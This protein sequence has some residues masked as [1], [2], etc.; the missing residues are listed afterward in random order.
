MV[1]ATSS[2]DS[3][4]K[5][6]IVDIWTFNEYKYKLTDKFF[7]LRNDYE[8]SRKMKG[9]TLADIYNLAKE[10]YNYLPEDLL[11]K[12][13]YEKLKIAIAG[14]IKYPSNREQYEELVEALDNYL[15]KARIP[16]VKGSVK[17]TPQEG[18]APLNVTLRGD[19]RDETGTKIPSYNYVWWVDDAGVRKVI[20]NKPS[21]NYIFKEE[22]TFSVYLDVTSAH[23]NSNGYTDVLPFRSR[24]D[25]TVKEKIASVIIKVNWDRLREKDELKYTPDEAGYGLIFDATSSTPT[26]GARFTRTEW[27]FGNGVE[28]VNNG[29]PE[30]ERIKYAKEGEYTVE[31]KL[32]TNENKTVKR[33]F[34]ISVH[35]PI[36]TITSS[37]DQGY[38]GDKFTFSAK[39]TGDDDNF[40]YDWEIIDITE[41]KTI[42][43]KSGKTFSYTFADKGKY[44]VKLRVTEPSWEVDIDTKIIY[45]NSRAP[46][47]SFISRKPFNN[48]PNTVFLD[49]S[50][51][52]DLDGKDDGKL[53]YEWI[54]NGDRTV[55]QNANYNNSTGY[56]TFDTVADH[57]VLLR[58]TD[59]EGISSQVTKKVNVNSI[60]SVDFG[61]YP[62]VA[63]REWTVRF[64]ADS[65]EATVYEWDFGD[66]KVVGGRTGQ[67]SHKYS[68]SGVYN[69]K[70][71][72]TD[73]EDRKNFYS[74]KVYISESNSPY[75][76]M[77]VST[78]WN[79]DVATES[80]L[81]YGEAAYVVDRSNAVTFN[82][83]E[84]IDV[85]GQTNGL[86]YTWKLGHNKYFSNSSFSQKF[87]EL[88]C[89]PIQLTVKSQTKGTT[90]KIKRYVKVVNLAPTLSHIDVQVVDGESD[91]VVVKVTAHGATDKDGVIQS[92]LW[93]YYTDI[94]P[95]PQDFRATKLANTTFV[96][97]KIT[98]NY[99]FV[100]MLKDDN[101]KRVSSEEITG[102]KYSITLTWD[103]INVP[104]VKLS[105]NDSSVSV[106][107]EISFSAE[108]ENILGHN[109]S[110]KA[111]Y[112]WDL[113]GDGFYEKK[114]DS[115]NI[116]YAY[117]QSWEFYAKV[118]ATYKGYSNTKSI[119]MNVSNLL[120][121]EVEYISIWNKFILLD[122]SLGKI[123]SRSWDLWDGSD[124]E[125]TQNVIHTFQGNDGSYVVKLTIEE[126]IK[127]ESE[128]FRITK[129]VRNFVKARKTGVIV[130]SNKDIEENIITVKDQKDK[131]Y[132]YLGESKAEG[133]G[134]ITD[135]VLDL[136]TE[137]DS[138]INGGTDDDVDES[139]SFGQNNN[140]IEISL[141]ERKTQT[142][143]I[144]AL[145]IQGNVIDTQLVAI[146]KAFIQEEEIDPNSIIFEWITDSEKITIEKIKNEVKQLPKQHRLKA[147]MYVQKL[148][149]EW[150]DAAE[151]TRVIVEFEGY[152]GE[153]DTPNANTIYELLESLLLE[154]TDDKSDQNLMF[155]A[156][157]N[158]TPTN[159]ACNLSSNDEKWVCYNAIIERLEVIKVSWDIEQNK[160][161]GTEILDA[162]WAYEDM[163]VKDKKD[164]K[165][166]LSS[167]VYW[168]VA[169]MPEEEKQEEIDT[170]QTG[171][172]PASGS[173]IMW[174]LKV[175]GWIIFIIIA[176]F[177]G[178]FG[179]FYLW[180]II[181]NKDDNLGF[182]DFII[183]K[184]SGRKVTKTLKD[185]T[186][187]ILQELDSELSE[188]IE[189]DAKE[190]I[191]SIAQDSKQVE[192]PKEES[193]A[194][195][196]NDSADKKDI[197]DWLQSTWQVETQTQDKTQE[198]ETNKETD[199][200]GIEE[201][202][203]EKKSD[204]Q[205]V[206][207][208]LKGSFET[209]TQETS[210][211]DNISED[212]KN[213]SQENT[214]LSDTKI[215]SWVPSWLKS[216][217]TGSQDDA[218]I[219]VEVPKEKTSDSKQKENID[220]SEKI[221]DSDIEEATKI[222]SDDNIPDWLKGSFETET[223]QTPKKENP[224]VDKKKD[225][226][227]M[228]KQ[229]ESSKK[230]SSWDDNIPDW[231]KGSFETDSKEN[232]E[233]SSTKVNDD[234][235]K[236]EKDSKKGGKKPEITIPNPIDETEEI[237]VEEVKQ[238]D[239]TDDSKKN[240]ENNV[241]KVVEK[242]NTTVK[243]TT[244]KKS[245]KKPVKK[246]PGKTEVNDEPKKTVESKDGN[247]K[248]TKKPPVKKTNTN[249]QKTDS[250]PK[251]IDDELW[252]DGMKI[253]DWLKTDDDK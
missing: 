127:S 39:P 52:Y 194:N 132:L 77:K 70:L 178:I 98:G 246:E 35:D 2:D 237:L 89:F 75:A 157:K 88:G 16:R 95:E 106:G 138:N 15:E 105:V 191:A 69:V 159:I 80:G 190:D 245:P 125:N 186:D 189:K 143:K 3:V 81:C 22:G 141:N 55:L 133:E 144:S 83:N 241:V 41:D 66:G 51:S 179:L 160:I 145:D 181:S 32:R 1:Y 23:K 170:P 8:V 114:T 21:I 207:D 84:S 12:N 119:T 130:F 248:S 121:P 235:K 42:F 18:N 220:K 38:L 86:D 165:A 111:K 174:V 63:Q 156:L 49:A 44:N 93:Y 187:E 139:L 97:P 183:E 213:D 99:Y 250:K 147:L 107:Q 13:L 19:V 123:D 234:A 91:P 90:H 65:P 229:S 67:I 158:L 208:W 212:N 10:G 50:K 210:K 175:V 184:T 120:R 110:K 153:I 9:D 231:L 37:Q 76:F 196:Q 151:K 28:R 5:L 87:D 200:K 34:I 126:W 226:Q 218:V 221:T 17:A 112:S 155:I 46:V 96:L 242:K 72:V 6:R 57:S 131:V 219:E 188:P 163:S 82:A 240:L 56:Y 152:V 167:F 209:E 92:Y 122:T 30:I 36:A 7:T 61:I 100:A 201:K 48:K 124:I 227:Q 113:D 204:D 26:G 53:K 135:F 150:F 85:T 47:A 176:L 171:D 43:N 109:L 33:E 118:K 197:P 140:I 251:K 29:G 142:V 128:S 252:D 129:N 71:T 60:L 134:E 116:S 224:S 253:P 223:K 206:P 146:E 238:S 247:K 103:N 20:G 205:G 180:Y 166:I 149:E 192:E 148:Q 45:I 177:L 58:V 104:L 216:E 168:G 230:E 169:N 228:E 172:K 73:R 54:I 232:Q 244:Q 222:E 202:Q 199:N 68:K 215:E 211:Q 24:A 115:P 40:A 101:E 117:E 225:S 173:A 236:E 4:T 198:I 59:P 193:Q 162:I 136:D 11:N 78:G 62:R 195:T 31:L 161:L 182:Q 102:S 154:D 14:A 239:D 203:S 217:E 164:Y 74:K 185:D 108:V 249:S 27:D 137:Y 94:D 64:V 79:T 233:S 243:K 214:E 25:I